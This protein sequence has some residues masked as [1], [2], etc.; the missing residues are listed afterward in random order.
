[1][2]GRGDTIDRVRRALIRDDQGHAEATRE[3]GVAVGGTD[4]AR[5]VTTAD[6]LQTVAIECIEKMGV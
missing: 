4:A 2:E 1:M 6:D 5:L 3:A